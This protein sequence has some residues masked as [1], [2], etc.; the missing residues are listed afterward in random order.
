MSEKNIK[1]LIDS[2]RPQPFKFMELTLDLIEGDPNQPRKAF[3]LGAGGD[4]NRLMKSLHWIKGYESGVFR[5]N[6]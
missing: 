6:V 2:F 3:G 4:Y 5:I 1:N